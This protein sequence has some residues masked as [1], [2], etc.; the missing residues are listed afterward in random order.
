MVVSA[1]ATVVGLDNALVVSNDASK[2]LQCS[3]AGG[4]IRTI[5]G[6]GLATS[7]QAGRAEV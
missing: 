1:P 6:K 4:C 5:E 2:S 7:I 3:Y